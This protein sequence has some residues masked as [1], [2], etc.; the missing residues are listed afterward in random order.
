MSGDRREPSYDFEFRLRLMQ[1]LRVRM[2]EQHRSTRST[3]STR[4]LGGSVRH[5]YRSIQQWLCRPI[6]SLTLFAATALGRSFAFGRS[7]T[8]GRVLGVLAIFAA[9]FFFVLFLLFHAATCSGPSKFLSALPSHR[10]Y[11]TSEQQ[12]AA[13]RGA[14]FR[15]SCSKVN[16]NEPTIGPNQSK[17][18]QN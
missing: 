18:S 15:Q 16:H 1:P 6:S 8:L 3:R 14:V 7:F 4:P 11:A 9:P 2:L 13:I 5:L 10:R 12:A 17:T